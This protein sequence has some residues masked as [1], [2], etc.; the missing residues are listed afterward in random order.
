MSA[1]VTQTSHPSKNP[2][3][4]HHIYPQLLTFPTPFPHENMLRKMRNLRKVR[5]IPPL[6]N[7]QKFALSKKSLT[8]VPYK[9]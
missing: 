2:R 5:K 6:K 1:G 9:T 3:C 8:F 4:H 7:A